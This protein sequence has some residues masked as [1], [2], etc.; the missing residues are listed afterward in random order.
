[1]FDFYR[2]WQQNNVISLSNLKIAAAWLCSINEN[3]EYRISCEFES[4]YVVY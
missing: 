1:M 2:L 3:G 4:R